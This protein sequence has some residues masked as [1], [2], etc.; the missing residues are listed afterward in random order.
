[1]RNSK[2]Q[3]RRDAIIL[4]TA[5][6]LLTNDAIAQH[7]DYGVSSLFK[8][9]MT[10]LSFRPALQGKYRTMGF[11][12]DLLIYQKIK[13]EDIKSAQITY[14]LVGK[15]LRENQGNYS[16]SA[17]IILS[18]LE[19]AYQKSSGKLKAF[20]QSAGIEVRSLAASLIEQSLASMMLFYAAATKVE[21]I[22]ELLWCVFPFCFKRPK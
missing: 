9:A 12:V 16:E 17:T 6:S 2:M 22:D 13:P 7:Y 11:Y 3:T 18:D 21:K 1:M 8:T 5:S 4:V 15:T 20:L 14:Q 19:A 10:D